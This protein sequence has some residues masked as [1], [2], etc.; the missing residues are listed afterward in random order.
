MTHADAMV[1]LSAL[2]GDLRL[3]LYRLL[4][5]RG[6]AGFAAGEL[7]ARLKLAPS[8]LS[9]HLRVLADAGLVTARRDGRF[10][11]YS[12]DFRRMDRLVGYLTENCC[13]LGD[14][15]MSDCGTDACRPA[16]RTTKRQRA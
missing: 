3:R 4:V 16:A 11:V 13:S 2:G 14:A 8:N 1:A 15:I 9:F 7:A 6:P 5:R 10:H 12:V